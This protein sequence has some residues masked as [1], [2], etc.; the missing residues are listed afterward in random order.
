MRRRIRFIETLPKVKVATPAYR[1]NQVNS[2]L[3]IASAFSFAG[4][5]IFFGTHLWR[6]LAGG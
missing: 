5:F 1:P 3:F 6:A 4:F 2:V